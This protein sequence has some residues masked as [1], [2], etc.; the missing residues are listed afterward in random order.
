MSLLAHDPGSGDR[1]DLLS[2]PMQ[3]PLVPV[4]SG[5]AHTRNPRQKYVKDVPILLAHVN[6][7]DSH[8]RRHLVARFEILP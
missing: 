3:I 7:F 5:E 1:C 4:L 8:S 6:E 2:Q